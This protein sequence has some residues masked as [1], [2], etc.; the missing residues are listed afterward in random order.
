MFTNYADTSKRHLEIWLSIPSRRSPVPYQRATRK[1]EHHVT[2][3][4]ASLGY[5]VQNPVSGL[6]TSSASE[7]IRSYLSMSS[8]NTVIHL[9]NSE[10][11]C[12][13]T[14]IWPSN[15][16]PIPTKV[17][18]R[19]KSGGSWIRVNK[20]SIFPGKFVKN[21]N[22]SGK[23]VKNFDFFRPI[24]EKFRFLSGNF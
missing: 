14:L 18:R 15:L 13:N 19:L 9:L 6:S 24:F 2:L 20:T 17:Q 11:T 4:V 5:I 16:E 12:C 7:W 21:F 8:G 3:P 1:P 10:L 23:F 22:F